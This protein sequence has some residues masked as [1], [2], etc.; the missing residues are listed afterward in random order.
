MSSAPLSTP[1]QTDNVGR[2]RDGI[3]YH[4]KSALDLLM[5]IEKQQYYELVHLPTATNG[6]VN[7]GS[8]SP[9]QSR[10]EITS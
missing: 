4:G 2:D 1:L 3:Q 7:G 8:G 6:L 5:Q 9:F 10:L